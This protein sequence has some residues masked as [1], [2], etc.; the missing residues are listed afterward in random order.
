MRILRECLGRFPRED[1]AELSTKG[2]VEID[3]QVVVDLGR[4]CRRKG[5]A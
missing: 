5:M 1:T 3:I 2:H 4:V